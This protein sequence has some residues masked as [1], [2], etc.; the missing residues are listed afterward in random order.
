MKTPLTSLLLVAFVVTLP[1]LGVRA[2]VNV[3]NDVVVTDTAMV[4]EAQAYTPPFYKG[5]ALLPDGGDVRILAFPPIELGSPYGLSYTWKVDGTV[6][7]EASGLGRSV[8]MHRSD[9]FGGSPL[10]VVEVSKNGTRASVGALRVPIIK[11]RVLMYPSLPLAGILFGSAVSAIEGN[12]ITL[13]AYPLF[14]GVETKFDSA[15]TY[16]WDINGRVASNPLGNTGRL[17]MR[18]ESGGDVAVGLSIFNTQNIL[19]SAESSLTITFE[20]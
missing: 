13:E 15:L 5:K 6:M 19:E 4:W 20:E 1:A 2:Q 16:R 12:E 7:P 17:T 10:I 3:T 14:F 9:I 18:S 8:F 11:P